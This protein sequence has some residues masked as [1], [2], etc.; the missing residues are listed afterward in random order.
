MDRFHTETVRIG[1]DEEDRAEDAL[2]ILS[3]DQ[4]TFAPSEVCGVVVGEHR[5]VGALAT[6][7]SHRL[8]MCFLGLLPFEEIAN[9][10]DAE[11]RSFVIPI[12]RK[13]RDDNGSCVLVL[14]PD[15]PRE[16]ATDGSC[17]SWTDPRLMFAHIGVH[18][19]R[20]FWLW[21]PDGWK[22]AVTTMGGLTMYEIHH[23]KGVLICGDSG[24]DALG[25][26]RCRI[27]D[28]I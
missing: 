6:T 24:V 22:Q 8:E 12:L 2:A 14:D 18:L 7:T 17:W 4:P 27:A 26:V 19:V 3:R 25:H 21:T 20:E 13:M 16:I 5:E 11:D 15:M 28:R 9:A 23:R 1:Q 10:P